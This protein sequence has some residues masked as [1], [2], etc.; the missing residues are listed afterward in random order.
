MNGV[1]PGIVSI[2]ARTIR[3]NVVIQNNSKSVPGSQGP[4]NMDTVRKLRGR[5]YD[6]VNEKMV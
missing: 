1:K 5:W 6:P 3:T 2:G 4:V